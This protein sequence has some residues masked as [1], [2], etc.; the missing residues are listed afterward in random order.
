MAGYLRC[1]WQTEKKRTDPWCDDGI[2][3]FKRWLQFEGSWQQITSSKWRHQS[4]KFMRYISFSCDYLTSGVQRWPTS[5]EHFKI[6]EDD[7][8]ASGYVSVATCLP[9]KIIETRVKTRMI[10][11]MDIRIQRLCR[12]QNLSL[13]PS[14][15]SRAESHGMIPHECEIS[16]FTPTNFLNSDMKNIASLLDTRKLW[17]GR[18]WGDTVVYRYSEIAKC[19][20]ERKQNTVCYSHVFPCADL[21]TSDH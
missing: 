13:S 21:N 11:P 12:N 15:L 7:P 3:K 9:L 6:G 20:W 17:Y 2:V 5:V 19:A 18:K 10:F 8:S 14:G 4:G 16:D 1:L